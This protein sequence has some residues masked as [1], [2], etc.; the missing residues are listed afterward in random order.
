MSLEGY[1]DDQYNRDLQD[2][3]EIEQVL[4][5]AA[6]TF[7]T[8]FDRR[9][10]CW[11]YAL[12]ATNCKPEV[13][14]S[15][16][17]SAMILAAIGKM[18]GCCTLRDGSTPQQLSELPE[19]LLSIFTRGIISLIK[20]L[21]EKGKVYSRT[22]GAHDPLTISHLTE[23]VRGLR[24]MRVSEKLEN[25]IQRTDAPETIKTLL[26]RNPA[27]GERF[28]GA[29]WCPRS[30]FI[31]LRI[32]RAEADLNR[33][34][35]VDSYK[36]FFDSL[37]HEQLSFSSIPD[38]RF[39]PAELAFC[40]EGLLICARESV[41]AVLFR[42]VLDVLAANQ[43]TSAFWRPTRPFKSNDRGEV[44]LPLSV[45]GANSLLRSVEI[46][47]GGKLYGTFA[48]TAVPMFRRFWQ[49][50]R[51]RKVEFTFLQVGCVGWHSEH[52]NETGVI[53]LWDTSQ[54][55]EFL[56]AFRQ[57]LKRHIARETLVLSRVKVDEAKQFKDWDKVRNKFEP[58]TDTSI[59]PRVFNQVE[60]DFIR[61][62]RDGEPAKNYSMLLYGPPGTGKTTI[63]SSLA[64]ALEFRLLTVTVSDFL[65][66]GGALVEARAKAIFQ[67]LGAQSDCVILFDEI[68]AFLLDRD[69]EHYRDQDTLF[70]FLTPG[71]L[72]KI[73]DLRK[74]ARSIFIIATN[75]ENRIDPAIKRP[76][77][78]DRQY[79]LLPPDLTK[80]KSIIK[81]A[82]RNRMKPTRE[83]MHQLATASLY[84]GYTEIV[85]AID[86][87]ARTNNGTIE[88]T[89]IVNAL[90]DTPRSSSHRH[91]L[92]RLPQE[93]TFPNN[94]FIAMAKLAL[95][96][97]KLGEV[98]ADIDSLGDEAKK[99]LR[100]IVSK[101]PN[102]KQEL[103]GM[104]V[105]V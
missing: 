12:K 74:A 59:A 101:S 46:M 86:T 93:T 30:G 32:V 71:M 55:V 60:A 6:V 94:E 56:V 26:S 85:G 70:Q 17:T 25:A 37:L 9:A 44:M 2:V 34:V 69:S 96:A 92:Y 90:K 79:L 3:A 82:V 104:G 54:V 24:G 15:Q 105:Q 20:Q 16:G 18:H 63:A 98:N 21:H 35:R 52:I 11:P 100:S 99:A 87:F 49:W 27:D 38:S 41:D 40:M 73:N 103:L 102:L 78:I 29:A 13:R 42:R 67:M 23:L 1:L 80:R 22:F 45:E 89:G 76:G 66:A 14:P 61:P 43:E 50:L 68:D 88:V 57:L 39:D 7:R 51:A 81:D 4:T 33:E 36:N 75:Y 95:Q 47:D 48:A 53:H 84:L 77:R 19:D 8:S 10:G 62:W 5:A 58:L 31:G 91:Y 65:G 28:L 72:T 64:D 97:E 83:E